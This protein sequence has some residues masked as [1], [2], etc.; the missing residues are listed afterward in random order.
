MQ[1]VDKSYVVTVVRRRYS[2]K[3]RRGLG[4]Y[5]WIRQS[6]QGSKTMRQLT[7]YHGPSSN[8]EPHIL[9]FQDH[10]AELRRSRFRLVTDDATDSVPLQTMPLRVTVTAELVRHALRLQ[11]PVG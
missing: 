6:V 2:L 1:Q 9:S 10:A 5:E 8:D 4:G 11:S 3:L 7:V